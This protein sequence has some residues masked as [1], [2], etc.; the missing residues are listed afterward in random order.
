MAEDNQD[1]KLTIRAKDEATATIEKVNK[2]L[3]EVSNSMTKTGK[4]SESMATSVFK[5]TLAYDALKQSV[6]VAVDF[7]QTFFHSLGNI[8]HFARHEDG[9]ITFNGCQGRAQFMGYGRDKFC[10]AL[11]DFINLFKSGGQLFGAFF[12]F[13]FQHLA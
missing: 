13:G 2:S 10:F 8:S 3:G 5:G 12:D 7:P 1:L 6:R 4:S 11:A 9:R